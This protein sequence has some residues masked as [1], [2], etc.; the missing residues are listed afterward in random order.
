METIIGLLFVLLPVILKLIGK[1]LEQSGEAQKAEKMRKLARELDGETDDIFEDWSGHEETEL[2]QELKP[3]AEFISVV[4]KIPV[5][6][7]VF[8][9]N[10]VRQTSPVRTKA[11]VRLNKPML[12]E[13]EMATKGEKIDPKKL[14]IYSEIMN[15]KYKE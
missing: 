1:K 8:T 2:E 5:V 4:P 7:P 9:E 14:V 12:Q 10:V 11:P 6:E 13:E 3:K 15:P